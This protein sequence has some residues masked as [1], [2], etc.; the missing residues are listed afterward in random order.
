MVGLSGHI[1]DSHIR[2]FE[3][4]VVTNHQRI[5][6]DD[7]EGRKCSFI[8]YFDIKIHFTASIEDNIRNSHETSILGTSNTNIEYH[9][10][11]NCQES[12]TS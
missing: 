8:H 7:A 1:T 5:Y 4:D 2:I 12:T 6:L 9:L 10:Q 3:S 11:E